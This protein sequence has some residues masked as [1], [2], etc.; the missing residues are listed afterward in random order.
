MHIQSQGFLA[1]WGFAHLIATNLSMWAYIVLAEAYENILHDLVV[2]SDDHGDD[3]GYD[4]G[5]GDGYGGKNYTSGKGSYDDHIIHKRTFPLLE[6]AL[7]ATSTI[8]MK[9]VISPVFIIN[10]TTY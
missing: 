6:L 4:K 7:L 1:R 2:N 8:T 9:T 5:Y 3:Y 10:L